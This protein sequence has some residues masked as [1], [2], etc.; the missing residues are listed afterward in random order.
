MDVDIVPQEIA[1]LQE[2][3]TDDSQLE[4]QAGLEGIHVMTLG[5]TKRYENS[6]DPMR[7]WIQH[8]DDYLAEVLHLEGRG[9]SHFN[10][11]TLRD[12]EADFFFPAEIVVPA[13]SSASGTY[14][15]RTNLHEL[16]LVV[17]LGHRPGI[18]CGLRDEPRS[19][20]VLH[21]NGVHT[22]KV[23][24]CACSGVP[25]HKQFLWFGWWPATPLEP[26]SCTTM[27]LLRLFHTLNLQGKIMAY[28]FYKSLELR[29]DNMSLLKLLDRLPAFMLMVRQ[30]H[31]I[32]MAKHV[33]HSYDSGSISSTNPG[34]LAIQCRACLHPGINLPDG[35]EDSSSADRWLYTL[36]ISHHQFLPLK[37]RRACDLLEWAV[38]CN[39]DYI[40]VS[41]IKS[42]EVKRLIVSYDIACQWYRNFWQQHEQILTSLQMM[43]PADALDAFVPKF[44]LPAHQEEC[45]APYS[46]NFAKCSQHEEMGPGHRWEMIDDICSFCNWRKTVEVGNAL[47]HRMLEAISEAVVHYKDFVKF[48]SGFKITLADVHL[49]LA[50]EEQARIQEGRDTQSPDVSPSSF[51]LLGMELEK[52]QRSL[53][54]LMHGELTT[55]QDATLQEQRA[56]LL[57]KILQFQEVHLAYMPS[58]PTFRDVDS[59][60]AE[61]ENIELTTH[62]KTKNVKGQQL[63]TRARAAQSSMD[64]R[65][66]AATLQYRHVHSALLSLHRHGP[67][68]D[69]LQELNDADVWGLGEHALMNEERAEQER[70]CELSGSSLNSFSIGHTG[71]VA[72]GEGRRMLSWLWYDVANEGGEAGLADSLRVEWVKVR[73]RAARWHKKVHLLNEEMHRVMEYSRWQAAIW[74]GRR[75]HLNSGMD[76]SLIE[77]LRAYAA[78]HAAMERELVASFEAKWSVVR[79][80]AQVILQQLDTALR[81]LNTNLGA[82]RPDGEETL[83]LAVES[84]FDA[85]EVDI[86]LGLDEDLENDVDPV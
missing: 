58:L 82:G 26:R 44:R 22:V 14:F 16:V 8:R 25:E 50:K 30:W 27:C 3:Q 49:K 63:N 54:R 37:S 57:K 71:V 6:D 60:H 5:R 12:A 21:T 51:L 72:V 70:I 9:P 41:S 34:G 32:K 67:W 23:A 15:K 45:H 75:D 10:I 20:T 43:L 74:I 52:Q 4:P 59:V 36:F 35:W 86:D 17:Q 19:I 42:V 18:L 38:Y 73:A 56:A 2:S 1:E 69:T 83:E 40:F 78:E 61:A 29:T 66:R 80:R 24:F 31:H 85:V 28:D 33:G 53:R 62:W 11:C 79:Q 47:L 81:E 77:G 76:A 13:M 64:A 68:E 7:T 48:T 39:M 55:H 65:V 84:A 46:F